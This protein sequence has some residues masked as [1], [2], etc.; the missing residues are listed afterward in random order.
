MQI[1]IRRTEPHDGPALQA[2]LDG[3]SEGDRT[4]FKE[5]FEDPRLV[6]SWLRPGGAR[7]SVA[8]EDGAV[9]GYAAVIP[10]HGWSAHVGEVRLIVTPEKR[11]QGVG[12]ALARDV[13]VQALELG[14]TKVVVEVVAD[15]ES[16]IAMFRSL[17]FDPEAVLRDHIRDRE[18]ALRD[19]I[20]LGHHVADA[21]SVM[22]T[23]GIPEEL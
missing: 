18:G 4:F 7:R 16:R 13:V 23:T 6:E 10:L 2:F 22:A 8:I 3:I 20:V 21:W 9:I 1:D 15:Q 17:G 12:Q 5:D 19:L 11:G 14:L